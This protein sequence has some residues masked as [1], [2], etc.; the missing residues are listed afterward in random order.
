MIWMERPLVALMQPSVT[1]SSSSS[2]LQQHQKH[3]RHQQHSH[4]QQH[5]PHYGKH[6]HPVRHRYP[7][8]FFCISLPEWLFRGGK[9]AHGGPSLGHVMNSD[10]CR[11]DPGLRP[12]LRLRRC[13]VF[14][15]RW[16]GGL[17]SLV[18]HASFPQSPHMAL[19]PN[20]VEDGIYW[21]MYRYVRWFGWRFR[22]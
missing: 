17:V 10:I 14:R 21:D 19:A 16:V 15:C 22:I 1:T 18:S 4:Q 3:H 6:H 7:N 9:V 20:N 13:R 5:H 8:L 12:R 2:I 11:G